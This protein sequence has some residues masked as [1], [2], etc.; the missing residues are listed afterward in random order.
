MKKLIIMISLSFLGILPAFRASAQADEIAQLILNIEKLAQFKQILSDMKK[1]YE[2]LSGGYNTIKNISEGNF[3]LHKAFLDGLME[4]SP[5]VR[6]YRRVADITNYQIILVKEYRKAYERFRQDNNFNADEL[7]YLG[8]VYDN[9]FKES[10]R[11]LDELLTVITA[12][13]ARM[14]DDERLQ[15]IDR[16]YADMQD[17]LMFLRHFNNNTTILAVQR[18]KERNDAQTIR[19]IYG[20]NN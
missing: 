7:A 2:I 4:V 12:G 1:G 8:R 13:K 5:A 6:N 11:N 9:L 10:L 20:L 14:S 15:A 3:S 19:K 17:K 18:A 16:I